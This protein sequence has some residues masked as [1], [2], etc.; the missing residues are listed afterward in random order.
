MMHQV[1]HAQ[2]APQLHH[3]L[4]RCSRI[5]RIA[6]SHKG[7]DY[8]IVLALTDGLQAYSIHL[9]THED[10]LDAPTP[11]WEHHRFLLGKQGANPFSTILGV[12]FFIM[13]PLGLH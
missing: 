7:R 4:G 9:E 6:P 12:H 2:S 10:V 3:T 1:H 8:V 5:Q 13:A 11:T